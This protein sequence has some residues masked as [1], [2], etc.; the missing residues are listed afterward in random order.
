MSQVGFDFNFSLG[1][2]FLRLIYGQF[3]MGVVNFPHENFQFSAFAKASAG[4]PIFFLELL[5]KLS[6]KV[7]AIRSAV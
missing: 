3:T 5:E 4:K 7:K 1:K 6:V 2:I